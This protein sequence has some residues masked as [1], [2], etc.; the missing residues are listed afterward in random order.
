M[1]Y[2]VREKRRNLRKVVGPHGCEYLIGLH[3]LFG[4]FRPQEIDCPHPAHL[5]A[6]FDYAFYYHV[7]AVTVEG[8]NQFIAPRRKHYFVPLQRERKT[9]RPATDAARPDDNY[10]HDRPLPVKLI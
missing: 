10:S 9:E 1:E 2:G 3:H 6:R 7:V 8:I 4:K 5:Y